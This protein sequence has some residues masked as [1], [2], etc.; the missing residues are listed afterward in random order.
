[1]KA[2]YK[3]EFFDRE[4]S[5]K[6]AYGR[7][8]GFARK[9]RLRIVIGVF[10]GM[11]TA[12]TLVPMFSLIQ[13]A[14]AKVEQRQEVK[15]K[16]EKVKSEVKSEE[17]EERTD[18][19]AKGLL[20]DYGKAKAFAAKIGFDLQD[21]DEALGLPLFF[22]IIVLLPLVA[23]LRCGLIFLN[24][25]CLAWAGMKTVRDIRCQLLKCINAQSM[26]FHGR[27]DVGQLMSRATSDPNSVQQIIQGMLAEV[28][29]A[30]FEILAAKHEMPDYDVLLLEEEEPTGPYGA[31]G[32]GEVV[33]APIAP[34]IL[35]AVNFALGTNLNRIPLTPAV[36]MGACKEV[37]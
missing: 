28:A 17:S 9:Y 36:V 27:I 19:K 10:C 4:Y 25:Y 11:L 21:D 12:G 20:K 26:Q 31:K 1:M 7:L 34:A 2:T 15:S 30:P 3:Q 29:R 24:H 13:P 32:I 35:E 22:A 18:K 14:L 5:A 16:S 37:L 6:E 8:W 23:L 33:L